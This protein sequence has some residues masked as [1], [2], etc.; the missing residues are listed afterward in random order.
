MV[1]EGYPKTQPPGRFRRGLYR[2]GAL[3]S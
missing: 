2:P 3:V 1:R